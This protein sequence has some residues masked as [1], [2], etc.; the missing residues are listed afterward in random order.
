[1]RRR[2]HDSARLPACNAA[3]GDEL[4]DVVLWRIGDEQTAVTRRTKQYAGT[5]ELT[6]WRLRI[7][8]SGGGEA[9]R[10]ERSAA[11][12]GCCDLAAGGTGEAS[13]Q[14]QAEAGAVMGIGA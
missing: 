7:R 1:V 8:G 5:G 14:R 4:Q 9:H 12:G 2:R 11:R 13:R 3:C 6:D 10:E